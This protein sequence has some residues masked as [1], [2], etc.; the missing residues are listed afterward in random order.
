[1]TVGSVYHGIKIKCWGFFEQN[2]HILKTLREKQTCKT[3]QTQ[4]KSSRY[5]P[6]FLWAA[7]FQRGNHTSESSSTTEGLP[8]ISKQTAWV[9]EEHF[10]IN[11]FTFKYSYLFPQTFY[12]QLCSL[13]LNTPD[14]PYWE[15]KPGFQFKGHQ[16]FGAR[17]QHL[18]LVQLSSWT[19]DIPDSLWACRNNSKHLLLLS[20]RL[21]TAY[22]DSSKHLKKQDYI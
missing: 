22:K 19:P 5:Y 7:S 9:T 16:Y 1:M 6:A 14:Y 12:S 4:P 2:L 11:L 18:N 20:F 13:L 3:H 17:K 8:K 21:N 15:A 10:N